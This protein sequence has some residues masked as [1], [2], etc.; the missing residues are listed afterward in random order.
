MALQVSRRSWHY[1]L[2]QYVKSIPDTEGPKGL[3]PFTGTR[4][5]DYATPKSLCPYAWSVFLGMIGATVVV[6]LTAVIAVPWLVVLGAIRALRW[7][8]N[9]VRL[10]TINFSS[11]PKAEKQKK[12]K[13]ES[14]VLAL[15]KSKKEK[16]CPMIE[17]VD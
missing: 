17:L 12:Q 7:A 9:S 6:L 2:Y 16:V 8:D 11:Q 4:R 14:L 15:I 5:L 3:F 1:R 13:G 10:P